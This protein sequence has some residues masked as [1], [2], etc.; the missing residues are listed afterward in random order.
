VSYT[1][2]RPV[3]FSGT[4]IEKRANRSTHRFLTEQYSEDDFETRC[5][6]CDCKPWH[7]TA[8]YPCGANVPRET[9]TVGE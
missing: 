3:E 8:N 2:T 5:T 6:E 4:E 7:Q 9:I 1:V